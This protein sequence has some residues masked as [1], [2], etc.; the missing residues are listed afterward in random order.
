MTKPAQAPSAEQLKAFTENFRAIV[1]PAMQRLTE[2][3][4]A[5][6]TALKPI[7]DAYERNPELFALP[8]PEAEPCHCLCGRHPDQP[9]ICIG[10]VEPGLTV[11][12]DSPT[13][14]LQH[15][16]MCR[17][18]HNAHM[19]IPV[20]RQPDMGELEAITDTCTCHCWQNHRDQAGVCTAAS[21]PG[22]N[23]DGKPACFECAAASR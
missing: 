9:D 16:P 21:D 11:A 15:V 13:V 17:N 2:Q 22:S 5:M 8:Q 12:F 7:V 18:C 14:G 20:D 1:M 23:I 19:G 10:R 3:F 4:A 6:R